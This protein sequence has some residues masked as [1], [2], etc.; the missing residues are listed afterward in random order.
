MAN[1]LQI[2]FNWA[3]NY[4]ELTLYNCNRLRNDD[5]ITKMRNEMIDFFQHF[6]PN[7]VCELFE[8]VVSFHYEGRDFRIL[9]KRSLEDVFNI[10][11]LCSDFHECCVTDY[12]YGEYKITKVS[13][14]LNVSDDLVASD[15]YGKFQRYM[16]DD[17]LRGKLCVW[18]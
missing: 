7:D 10:E 17:V 2:D 16:I 13:I 11:G 18:N 3:F 5:F 8:E 12:Y 6:V 4:I 15:D 9:T 1:N 14:C